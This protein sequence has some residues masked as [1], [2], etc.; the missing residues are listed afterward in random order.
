MTSLVDQIR[1]WRAGASL[2]GAGAQSASFR[3]RDYVRIANL[4]PTLERT[5]PPAD[6]G[7]LLERFASGLTTQEVAALMTDGND[8]PDRCAA[9]AALIEVAAIAA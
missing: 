7:P 8:A 6:P 4:D 1:S 2:G 5:P 3:A 9:E